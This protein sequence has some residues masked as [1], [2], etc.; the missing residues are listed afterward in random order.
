MV[1]EA[2]V[3]WAQVCTAFPSG[4]RCLRG[5]SPCYH[6]HYSIAQ[7]PVPQGWVGDSAVESPRGGW[8][9]VHLLSD[10]RSPPEAPSPS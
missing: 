3:C 8:A 9:Q 1:W 2:L 6:L 10:G 5:P 4:Q 7:S